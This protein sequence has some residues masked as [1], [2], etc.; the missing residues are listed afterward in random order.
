MQWVALLLIIASLGTFPSDAH[1]V[2]I[3]T[4]TTT[5][6]LSICGNAL[7]DVGEQCDIPGEIG[8]YSTTIAGRQCNAVYFFGWID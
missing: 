2:T 3:S 7:I 8:L 1:A 5:I 6:D 4:A